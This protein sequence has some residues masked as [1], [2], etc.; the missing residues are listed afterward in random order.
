M[1]FNIVSHI[2]FLILDLIIVVNEDEEG[3]NGECNEEKCNSGKIQTIL[4]FCLL[5]WN[6]FLLA[7]FTKCFYRVMTTTKKHYIFEYHQ[8]KCYF[9][10]MSV[11]LEISLIVLVSQK[12]IEMHQKFE[13]QHITVFKY[14]LTFITL[15]PISVYLFGKKVYDSLQ[16]FNKCSITYSN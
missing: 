14:L 10:F 8:H 11:I 12:F 7:Y 13:W 1:L 5:I 2:F 9:V 4:Y 15:A 16:S 6:L 3:N